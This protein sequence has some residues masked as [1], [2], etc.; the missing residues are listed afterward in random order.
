MAAMIISLIPNFNAS[1][2]PNVKLKEINE[3]K[4]AIYLLLVAMLMLIKIEKLAGAVG[5]EAM[6]S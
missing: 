5:G 3:L 2:Q 1:Y 6:T 4:R